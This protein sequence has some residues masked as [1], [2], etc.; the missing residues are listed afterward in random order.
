MNADCMLDYTLRTHAKHMLK[1]EIS[2]LSSVEKM[3]ATGEISEREYMMYR[4]RNNY[5]EF[6]KSLQDEFGEEKAKEIIEKIEDYMYRKQ[7]LHTER[8]D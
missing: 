5:Q 2:L 1:P 6:T 7:V 8:F 3:Y 4:C